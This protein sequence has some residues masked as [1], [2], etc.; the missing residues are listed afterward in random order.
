[1]GICRAWFLN[2]DADDELASRG[3]Y[4]PARA[5][6]ARTAAMRG[7]LAGLLGPGDVILD[8]S[9][10][11][12]RGERWH[13]VAWCP[14]PRAIRA[15][16]AAG[17]AVPVA[18]PFDVLRRVNHRRFCAELG[19]TLPSACYVEAHAELAEVL[20]AAPPGSPWLLKRPFGF[21]GRGRR[22]VAAGRLDPA[23]IPWINASLRAGEG[24]QAEPWA[25]RVGDFAL[26]GF[27]DRGGH[28]IVGTPTAQCCDAR[29]AWSGSVQ[30]E[31]AALTGAEREALESCVH[32]TASALFSA[33]YWGPFGV[34]AFRW[35]DEDGNMRWNPRCEINARY[36]MGWAIGMGSSRPDLSG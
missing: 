3:S 4:T 10:P 14:T 26:H 19:Q 23:D 5:V 17:A 31:P 15:L 35:R 30:C 6:A 16:S 34:D 20:G 36:S 24:L 29:G 22:R 25:E 33:G 21:A 13:G 12:T 18:P 7:S 11:L 1:M 32:Q 8:E 2:L 28:V 27:L 9:I